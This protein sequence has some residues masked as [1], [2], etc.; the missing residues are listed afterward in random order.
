[1]CGDRQQAR[2]EMNDQLGIVGYYDDDKGRS[3]VLL[4]SGERVAIKPHSFA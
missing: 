4:P 3:A 1:M 2:P